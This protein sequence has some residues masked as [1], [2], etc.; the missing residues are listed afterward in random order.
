MVTR[1]RK[2][3]T[4]LIANRRL[5]ERGRE[6]TKR[7]GAHVGWLAGSLARCSFTLLPIAANAA[8]NYTSSSL[9]FTPARLLCASHPHTPSP[10]SADPF[11]LWFLG[12]EL[13]S[14]LPLCLSFTHPPSG[15][16]STPHLFLPPLAW[17]E[18]PLGRDDKT[19]EQ[20]SGQ[21]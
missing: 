4:R 3:Q 17:A 5:A 19:R 18:A 21:G 12:C 16:S 1:P 9:S 15:A 8:E 6:S 20:R 7:Y 11:A 14:L 10:P 2:A 13:G